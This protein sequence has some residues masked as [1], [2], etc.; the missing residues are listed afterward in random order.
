[1]MGYGGWGIMGGFGGL[2]M[3]LG[4]VF[5]V[6]VVLLVVWGATRLFSVQ[7]Q[8]VRDTAMDI[9]QRRYATGEISAAEFEGAKRD[10]AQL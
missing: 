3:I 10:L 2:G 4:L 1:M 9:L 7:Q 6:G 5:W 8:P